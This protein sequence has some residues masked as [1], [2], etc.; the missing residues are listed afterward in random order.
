LRGRPTLPGFHCTEG[1]GTGVGGESSDFFR[2][3]KKKKIFPI[4][5]PKEGEERSAR[6]SLGHPHMRK[7]EGKVPPVNPSAR[8]EEG[9]GVQ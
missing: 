5:Q 2:E 1:K 6:A 9:R 3:K 8:L 7:R 4:N